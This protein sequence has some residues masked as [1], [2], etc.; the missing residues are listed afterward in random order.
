VLW[1]AVAWGTLGLLGGD[2]APTAEE[3]KDLVK[4]V[5]NHRIV[6]KVFLLE[7]TPFVFENSP[8]RYVIFREQVADQFDV[9]SQDV[10]I[11]GSAKL[12]FRRSP[13]KYGT[14]FKDTSDVD[15]VIV[16]EPLFDRGSREL[17]KVLNRLDPSVHELRPFLESQDPKAKTS[18]MLVVRLS[19][20]KNVK[21]AIRNFVF[22]NFNPGLLPYDHALRQDIFERISSTSGLFLALE[23]KVFVSK[24]R[25]RI[26]RTWKS[27]EDYYANSLREAKRAFSGEVVEVESDDGSEP[28]VSKTDSK[29]A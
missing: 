26:F 22:Q 27:A 29:G 9:G 25:G 15:V 19:D 23:P 13:Y 2:K 5:D 3:F 24:I 16:S 18:P 12:G 11:V 28:A 21:E 17:F 4:A 20:W 7:G 10:C 1:T 8:M 14:P 6:A